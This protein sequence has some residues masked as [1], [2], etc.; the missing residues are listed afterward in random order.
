MTQEAS[1]VTELDA[2]TRRVRPALFFESITFSDG[3]ILTFDQ[4]DI[5]VFVGP[6][7]A[8][9]SATLRELES[10]VGFPRPGVVITSA[11]T[12]KA[13]TVDDL[14]AFLEQNSQKSG[15]AESPHYGGIGYN[16]NER[17]LHYFD[18]VGDRRPVAPFFARRLPTETRI[19]DSDAAPAIALFQSPPTHPIHMLL[20]DKNLTADI[21]AKFRH[22]FGQDLTP[23]RAGGSSFPLYVGT[24]P[25]LKTGMD[26]LSREFIEELQRTNVLLDNQGD[27]MRSFAAV[28]LHVLAARTHSIQFLDE[29][30]AFLHPPQARLLG[31]YIAESR[32]E[33]SQLFIATH[34][35]DILDGLIEGGSSKVRIIRLRRDGKVNRVKELGK[36]Q[37]QA[38]SKDTLTHFSRV[39]DG[40]FF[41]HV[42]ICESDADC[43]FYQSILSLRSISS[44]RRPDVLFVHTAGKHRM[45]KLADTLRA[46]DVPVSV[47][48]DI[49]VLN[50]ENTFK[51]LIESLGGNWPDIRSH[52]K[53]ISDAVISQRPPLNA[54]QVTSMIAKEIDGMTGVG[55]F[56][57][58]KE[59]N[60]KRI[61]KTIS[62]WSALK[63]SGRMALPSGEVTRQFDQLHEKCAVL[64]LWMVPVGE[65]EGFCRSIGSHGPG[66]VEKVLEERNLETD[67]ELK[68]AR[69]F[70]RKLWERATHGRP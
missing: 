68:E 25:V 31:K 47:V 16:I 56:P 46:L 18:Q 70:V 42:I 28:L 21:S 13:G 57:S 55:E 17:N 27:G 69:D 58:D 60:I 5:V 38:I 33:E 3:T 6:N 39:F 37:T 30:E 26:E 35:A 63:Q 1:N 66:F 50:E 53:A 29:P 24:K 36:D 67:E 19:K 51:R 61:F 20:M 15:N 9:K 48:A 54:G 43:M 52:W 23:F 14:R 65:I 12:R 2:S 49:D 8:G 34:S 41:E 7:N 44:D 64:G 45:A 40:I 22:A 62:P 4:D 11:T 59:N 10:W 32:R